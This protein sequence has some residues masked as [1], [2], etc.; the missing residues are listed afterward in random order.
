MEKAEQE[1]EYLQNLWELEDLA[2]KKTQ[3]YARLL[4]EPSLAAEME[5]LSSRHGERK[6]RVEKLLYGK[7]QEAKRE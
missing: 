2:E 3:I 5:G 1:R 7:A 6:A 4:I